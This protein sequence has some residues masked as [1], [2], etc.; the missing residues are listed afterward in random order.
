MKIL[1]IILTIFFFAGISFAEPP[2]S[3]TDR[4]G[5]YWCHFD[6]SHGPDCNTC[7]DGQMSQ[8]PFSRQPDCNKVCEDTG[9]GTN[10]SSARMVFKP[11]KPMGKKAKSAKVKTTSKSSNS[12]KKKPKIRKSKKKK[13]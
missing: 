7:K 5:N 1:S 3:S 13:K 11:G 2:K 12:S 9:E 4:F 10:C 8:G 6:S